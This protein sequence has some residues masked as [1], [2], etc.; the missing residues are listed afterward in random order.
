MQVASGSENALRYRRLV[1]LTSTWFKEHPLYDNDGQPIVVPEWSFP[2]RG[3][4]Q[5][6]LESA[7]TWLERAEKVLSNLPLRGKQAE[8]SAT[9]EE[10]REEIERALGYVELYGAYAECEAVYGARPAASPCGIARPRRTRPSSTS[11]RARSTGTATSPR[12]TC[13]RSSSTAG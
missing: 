6:Q 8:L 11:T 7:K 4:V 1:N 10:R 13:R 5:G 2:G 12:S 3:R 9:V